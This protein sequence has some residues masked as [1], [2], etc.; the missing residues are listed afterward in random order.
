[1]ISIITSIIEKYWKVLKNIEKIEYNQLN[2]LLSNKRKIK[3][4]EPMR[5]QSRISIVS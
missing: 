1:M 4:K 5:S 3:M 2:L